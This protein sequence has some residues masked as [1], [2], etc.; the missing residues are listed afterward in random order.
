MSSSVYFT[1]DDTKKIQ[2]N[3]RELLNAMPQEFREHLMHSF[4][5]SEDKLNAYLNREMTLNGDQL[6]DAYS[7]VES[8]LA[9]IESYAAEKSA[10]PFPEYDEWVEKEYKNYRASLTE[11]RDDIERLMDEGGVVAPGKTSPVD[12]MA[13][14]TLSHYNHLRSEHEKTQKRSQDALRLMQS[15]YYKSLKNQALEMCKVIMESMHKH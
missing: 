11:D 5:W 3:V 1:V 7:H 8:F 4:L 12:T 10:K 13:N 9:R 14:D 2:N 6:K 15:P